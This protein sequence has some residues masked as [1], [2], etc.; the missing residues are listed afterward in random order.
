MKTTLTSWLAG[1]PALWLAATTQ[2]P[3]ADYTAHFVCTNAFCADYDHGLDCCTSY[4]GRWSD[5]GVWDIGQVPLN[6]GVDV[7]DVVWEGGLCSCPPCSCLLSLD[8]LTNVFIRNF[9]LAA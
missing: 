9:T 1:I 3:A 7:Y 8:V 4:E 6:N 2:V 5:P